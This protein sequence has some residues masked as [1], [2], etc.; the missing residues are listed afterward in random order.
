[1]PE[2]HQEPTFEQLRIA[3]SE[4]QPGDT[5]FVR[6]KGLVSKLILAAEGADANAWAPTHVAIIVSQSPA[7]VADCISPR[8]VIQSL[9]ESLKEVHSF[10]LIRPRDKED[11]IAIA[12]TAAMSDGV[13]YGYW[14]LYIMAWRCVLGKKPGNKAYPSFRIGFALLLPWVFPL[15]AMCRLREI[16]ENIFSGSLML[17]EGALLLFLTGR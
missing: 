12:R 2:C 6:G 1:M 16:A 11:G 4:V 5:L 14:S 15:F 3:E 8:I 7:L 10:K 9:S 17:P 13:P